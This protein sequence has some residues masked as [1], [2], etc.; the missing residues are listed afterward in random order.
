MGTA[1]LI[2]SATAFP[3]STELKL[4]LNESI[5]AALL[6][7]QLQG[8]MNSIEQSGRRVMMV[9]VPEH[10]AAVRGDTIQMARLRDI[11]SPHITQVPVMVKYFGMT[12]KMT[13]VHVK[14]NTSYLALSELIARSIETDVYAKFDPLETIRGLAKSLPQTYPVS[15]NSNAA[16][17]RFQDRY[18][19][20]LNNRDWLPYQQ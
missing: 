9:V 19:V 16:V 1:R 15:E 18:F 14:E 17:I 5:A 13:P 3:A 12:E 20:R 2:P 6:L 4:P 7:D 10:G 8:L 11:P